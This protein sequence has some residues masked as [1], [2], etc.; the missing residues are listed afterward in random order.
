MPDAWPKVSIIIVNWNNFRD[1]AECLDSLGRAT[2]A[3]R[4]VVVVDN[5]SDGE[6][7]ALLRERF[8][9]VV[10]LIENGR[11]E[12]FAAGCNKGIR[13]ALE[14]DADYVVLLNNDTLVAP[15]FLEELVGAVREDG[16]VGVAGGKVYCEEIPDMI[17]FAGGAIDYWRG[18]TPIRGSGDTDSGQYDEVVEVDWICGCFMLLSRRLL[19]EVGLLDERFFFGWEDADISLRAKKKG[20]RVIFVPAARIWHKTLPPGKQKRLTG[21]PVYYAMRGYLV[22]VER[23][24]TKLQLLSTGAYFVARFPRLLQDYSRILGGQRSVPLYLLWGMAG[25]VGMRLKDIVKRRPLGPPLVNGP[26]GPPT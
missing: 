11:N 26:V 1:T 18:S 12:G 3:N 9:G 17:W 4:E 15:D 10:R 8:G 7:V 21:P 16:T 22:F 20:F 19:L 14:R 25:Y 6:D 23:H 24:L 2:Y 13:D 5:G